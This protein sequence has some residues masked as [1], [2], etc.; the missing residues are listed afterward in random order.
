M[1]RNATLSLLEGMVLDL[2]EQL[3]E[4]LPRAQ[5]KQVGSK[6]KER[7]KIAVR[8]ADRRKPAQ[9]DGYV[10]VA[11]RTRLPSDM[12]IEIYTAQEP[13]NPLH[14]IPAEPKLR[15]LE[16]HRCS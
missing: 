7:R 8:L 14:G 2:L 16:R 6:R 5:D 12:L 13:R 4:A 9:A 10:R 11:A 15:Q 3:S 1:R